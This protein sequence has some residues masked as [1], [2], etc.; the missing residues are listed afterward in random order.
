MNNAPFSRALSS[1]TCGGTCKTSPVIARDS[2]FP[3][4]QKIIS[5]QLELASFCCLIYRANWSRCKI[6]AKSEDCV[7]GLFAAGPCHTKWV[8]TAQCRCHNTGGKRVSDTL[9]VL[10][11]TR[12]DQGRRLGIRNTTRLQDI[13]FCLGF[14]WMWACL[15][16]WQQRTFALDIIGECIGWC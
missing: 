12:K 14:A 2:P 1:R 8:E 10:T 13:L 3:C 9:D 4:A 5:N 16:V 11:H 15:Y 7:G 6:S